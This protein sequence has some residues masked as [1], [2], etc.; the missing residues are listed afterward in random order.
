MLLSSQGFW[1]NERM[2]GKAGCKAYCYEENRPRGG[3]ILKHKLLP[4]PSY[5]V[6]L[7]V[8]AGREK[9]EMR[10]NYIVLCVSFS[11]LPP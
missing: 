9:G 2:L 3:H 11:L 10:I 6:S 5:G 1:P 8:K 4:V 7:E